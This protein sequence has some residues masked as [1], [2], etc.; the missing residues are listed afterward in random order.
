MNLHCIRAPKNPKGG[1]GKFPKPERFP[2]AR[3]ISRGRTTSEVSR[4]E[5]NL[6]CGGDD[7]PNISPDFWCNTNTLSSTNQQTLPCGQ[8]RIDSAKINPSLLIMRE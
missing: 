5:G 1:I 3:E 7:F 8:G 6:K 4:V 2:E